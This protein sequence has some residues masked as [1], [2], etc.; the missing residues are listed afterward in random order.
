MPSRRATWRASSTVSGEQQLP[1]RAVRSSGSRHGHTRSVMPTT[2]WPCSTSRAAA[3][4]ESTPPLIP[5]T[6]RSAMSGSLPAL[7]ARAGD[8]L[9]QAVQL[10]ARG[11]GDLDPARALGPDQ[12]HPRGERRAERV[13]HGGQVG[14]SPQQTPG[15]LDA[16]LLDVLFGCADRPRV[17][18]DLLSQ[19]E[20]LGG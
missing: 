14:G 20:L 6:T 2:S 10:F 15:R 12:P 3:T 9:G 13:L 19:L 17:G 18:E 8:E 5:T 7:A 1:N 16:L 11:V 4:E